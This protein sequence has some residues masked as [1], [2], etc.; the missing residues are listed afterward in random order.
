MR[1]R[2]GGLYMTKRE[3]R[4]IEEMLRHV[5]TDISYGGGGT[6]TNGL[7]DDNG[8]Y[9]VDMKAVTR[10]KKAIDSVRWILSL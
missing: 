2:N 10:V 8:D 9:I 3:K 7:T 1:T 5:E 6:F 4:D